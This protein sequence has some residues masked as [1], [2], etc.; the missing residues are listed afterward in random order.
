[1]YGHKKLSEPVIN[2]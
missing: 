2:E 1:M